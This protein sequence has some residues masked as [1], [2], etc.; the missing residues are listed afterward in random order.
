MMSMALAAPPHSSPWSHPK[1]R[2]IAGKAKGHR[3]KS[4]KDSRLRP[5]SDLVR[6]AIFSM[7][8]S[9]AADYSRVL[10]LYAGTGALGIE[11]LSRG[12]LSADFVEQRPQNCA[13]IKENLEYTGFSTQARVYCCAVR[14]A[15]SFLSGTYTLVLLDPPYASPSL[16]DTLNKLLTSSL[17]GEGSTIVVEHSKRFQTATSYGDFP[18]AVSRRHGDTCI[19][20]YLRRTEN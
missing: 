3:L 4:P 9:L 2:I 10:D 5:T 12:A 20:I 19:S 14:K 18:L 6:G 11:A 16:H 17:V 1:M 15:L 13:L 8:D 7:L